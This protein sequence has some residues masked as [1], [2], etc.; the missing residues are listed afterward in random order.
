[1]LVPGFQAFVLDED[2]AVRGVVVIDH[3]RAQS[4]LDRGGIDVDD[5]ETASCGVFQH[6]D[7]ASHVAALSPVIEEGSLAAQPGPRPPE[8]A[9]DDGR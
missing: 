1:L 2:E 7:V 5:L 9:V 6:V 8:G 4:P 3:I